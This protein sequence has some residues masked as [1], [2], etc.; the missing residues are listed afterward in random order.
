MEHNLT[1]HDNRISFHDVA[2]FVLIIL[3]MYTAV[4][5]L[6]EFEQFQKQMELQTLP[7]WLQRGLIWSLPTIEIITGLL[8]AFVRTRMIGFYSSAILMTLFT[9]YVALV[10]LNFFGKV[11]CS[12]GGVIKAMGW[13]QHLAFNVFFLLLSFLGIHKLNGER[14]ISRH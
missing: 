10:L 12:C 7:V 13:E 9:G 3:F 8:L 14:R 11:P 2:A 4:S 5:K 6:S 1:H